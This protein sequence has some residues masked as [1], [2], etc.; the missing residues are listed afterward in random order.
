MSSH[1]TLG[2]EVVG[3][4]LVYIENKQIT[5]L[6]TMYGTWQLW[7]ELGEYSSFFCFVFG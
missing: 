5:K 3:T 1:H 6:L 4:N 2:A 7:L